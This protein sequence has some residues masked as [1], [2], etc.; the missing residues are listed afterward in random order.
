M[1]SR[2]TEVL[3]VGT[4]LFGAASFGLNAVSVG[5]SEENGFIGLVERVDVCSLCGFFDG[6]CLV[7]SFSYSFFEGFD[8]GGV[9]LAEDLEGFSCDVFR[10]CE[11]EFGDIFAKHL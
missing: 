1:S 9:S 3:V 5:D 7:G 11:S 4:D 2:H 6:F 10:R 8:I